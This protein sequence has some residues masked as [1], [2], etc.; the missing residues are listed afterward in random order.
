MDMNTTV[1]PTTYFPT[2][3]EYVPQGIDLDYFVQVQNKYYIKMVG[4][5]AKV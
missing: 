5:Y 3:N 1:I 4:Q 2:K